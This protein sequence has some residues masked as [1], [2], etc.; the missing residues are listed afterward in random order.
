[1]FP[2]LL[3]SRDAQL[4]DLV[5]RALAD[6]AERGGAR[7]ACR[8]GC[9]PCCHGVFR[10][11]ALDATRLRGGLQELAR[12]D[13]ARAAAIAQRAQVAVAALAP[14]YPGGP[15][16]GWLLPPDADGETPEWDLF[17]DLPEADRACPVL[18][19]LTGQCELYTARPLTCRVFGPP[20]RGAEGVGV[21]ELCYRGAGEAEILA[22]E[23]ILTHQTLEGELDEELEAAGHGGETI[24]AWALTTPDM[25]LQG[26][27]PV[28]K[29]EG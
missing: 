19:P 15:H 5:D 9:T 28:T 20:V 29:L 24:I 27:I 14:R 23:M 21:C 3:P 8:P 11:S 13:T 25:E 1:M 7:L 17:A 18:D 6:A 12:E 22:G 2:I 16:T 10:I 26:S 4:V